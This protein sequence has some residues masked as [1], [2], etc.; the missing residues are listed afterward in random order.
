MVNHHIRLKPQLCPNCGYTLDAVGTIDG[1]V[2]MPKRGD[3]TV[4]LNCVSVLIFDRDLKLELG[5]LEVIEPVSTRKELQRIIKGI[6][7][8]KKE[9][10]WNPVKA[11][12][13]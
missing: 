4:C 3:C 1:K 7:E 5:K 12:M 13:M 10:P 9:V 8:M 11:V 2:H 6:H